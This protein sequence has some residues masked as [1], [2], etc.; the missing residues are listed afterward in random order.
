MHW[1]DDAE[2]EEGRGYGGRVRRSGSGRPGVATTARGSEAGPSTS[3]A[4]S[5]GAKR[6]S[7]FERLKFPDEESKGSGGGSTASS[8]SR[9]AVFSRLGGAAAP[10]RE[11]EDEEDDEEYAEEA[12]PLPARGAVR[13]GSRHQEAAW[14]LHD[15]RDQQP[16]PPSSSRTHDDATHRRTPTATRQPP[17]RPSP[18]SVGGSALAGRALA[19]VAASREGA[20]SLGSPELRQNVASTPLATPPSTHARESRQDARRGDMRSTHSPSAAH[21]HRETV[22]PDRSRAVDAR[23]APASH[24]KW[25]YRDPKGNAQGPNKASDLLAW[26]KAGYFAG[27]MPVREGNS[28]WQALKSA[29]PALKRAAGLESGTPAVAESGS[30]K[31]SRTTPQQEAKQMEAVARQLFL[32]VGDAGWRY[33]DNNGAAQGPFAGDQMFGWWQQ[34]F[35]VP[36]LRMG[37][38]RDGNYLPLSELLNRFSKSVSTP[39]VQERKPSPVPIQ[40]PPSRD[41]KQTVQTSA[42]Q[43]PPA[44]QI[45]KDASSITNVTTL[46]P[47]TQSAQA[48]EKREVEAQAPSADDNT[49]HPD[50]PQQDH[51]ASLSRQTVPQ[52]RAEVEH[53]STENETQLEAVVTTSSPADVADDVALGLQESERVG[54][55]P[56]ALHADVSLRVGGDAESAPTDSLEGT[57]QQEVG[58]GDDPASRCLPEEHFSP[59]ID[60]VQHIV[61]D[62]VALSIQERERVG[63]ELAVATAGVEQGNGGD[64]ESTPSDICEG[65]T[66]QDDGT[67]DEPASRSLPEEHSDSAVDDT[68]R[69][70][71]AASAGAQTP[72]A[73][74]A[75]HTPTATIAESVQDPLV[76]NKQSSNEAQE[77]RTLDGHLSPQKSPSA[78]DTQLS[79]SPADAA[80]VADDSA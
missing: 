32:S 40:A 28:E 55:E 67:G 11:D 2:N 80:H 35:F 58:T 42:S 25:F 24:A 14:F 21:L 19:E 22:A 17:V 63:S 76:V 23:P 56:A 47:T 68:E 74:T 49:S 9:A 3:P 48:T 78:E 66:Q 20:A 73:D 37:S 12:P 54:N 52:K 1:G 50:A 79:N 6:R 8:A 43:P 53:A 71:A 60:E 51:P 41:S 61:T 75:S 18:R 29:I 77:Q 26:Y 64:V 4:G 69:E 65:M 5:S 10:S 34:G 59:A 33:I 31:T 13:A 70:Q 30:A 62:D 27:E 45:I 36:S 39:A 46:K 16:A 38:A 7:V 15:D 44:R 72:E 57:T